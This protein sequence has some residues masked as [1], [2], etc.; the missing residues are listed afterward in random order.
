MKRPC[1]LLIFVSVVLAGCAVHE[2]GVRNNELYI[3]LN[4]PDAK[5][6]YF[7]SSLDGFSLHRTERLSSNKWQIIIPAGR[8]LRYFYI[9]DGLMYTPPCRFKERDDFGTEN[10]IYVPGM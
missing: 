10:C 7:A 9:I 2:Y 5:T 4:K 6:V 1:L 8:E 3:G